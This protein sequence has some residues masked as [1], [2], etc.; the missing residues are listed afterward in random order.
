MRYYFLNP[1]VG[2]M[3]RSW[4][5]KRGYTWWGGG[6]GGIGVGE[7]RWEGVNESSIGILLIQPNIMEDRLSAFG[8]VFIEQARERCNEGWKRGSALRVQE[9]QSF[10]AGC[11]DVPGSGVS[12]VDFVNP[13]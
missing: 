3:G 1:F 5:W 6:R 7:V 8:K 12:L 4:R 10:D 11:S 9:M 13:L 2:A